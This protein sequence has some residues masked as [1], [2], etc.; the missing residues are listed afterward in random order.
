MGIGGAYR[1]LRAVR[2]AERRFDFVEEAPLSAAM[3]CHGLLWA[4][5]PCCGRVPRADEFLDFRDWVLR[6]DVS[7]TPIPRFFALRRR[8]WS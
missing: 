2:Q 6:F 4:D 3:S 5:G 8:T 1:R 7:L